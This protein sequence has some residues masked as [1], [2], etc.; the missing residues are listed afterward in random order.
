[1][2]SFNLLP[3]NVVAAAG[4]LSI[5]LVVSFLPAAISNLKHCGDWTGVAAE[6]S[7]AESLKGHMALKIANNSVVLTIQNLIPPI[8]PMANAWNRAVQRPLPQHWRA[9]LEETF[10]PVGAHW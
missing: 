3:R 9:K 10:E 5:A 8:F 6:R 7:D 1:M 2:P 4:A